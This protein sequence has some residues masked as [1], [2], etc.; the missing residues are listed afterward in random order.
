M[1]DAARFFFSRE[2]LRRPLTINRMR[3]R[4]ETLAETEGRASPISRS[5]AEEETRR[6]LVVSTA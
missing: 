2:S 3:V 1:Q 4:G 6:G 5:K